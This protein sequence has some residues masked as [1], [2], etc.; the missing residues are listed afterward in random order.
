MKSSNIRLKNSGLETVLFN[1]TKI[2]GILD[3]RLMGYYKIKQGMLMDFEENLPFQEG[4]I[5]EMYQSP[6]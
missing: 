1:L 6:Q 4:V 2:L 3:I 5:S